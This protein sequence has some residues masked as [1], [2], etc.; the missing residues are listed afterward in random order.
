M[1]TSQGKNHKLKALQRKLKSQ[2]I[3]LIKKEYNIRDERKSFLI[4]IGYFGINRMN[5][6]GLLTL[7]LTLTPDP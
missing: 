5:P 7:T 1:F 3:K 4:L 2:M 6:S